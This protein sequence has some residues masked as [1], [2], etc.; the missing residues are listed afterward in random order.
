MGTKKVHTGILFRMSN[1][2]KG[3]ITNIILVSYREFFAQ[4][5]VRIGFAQFVLFFAPQSHKANI[6]YK[7]MTYVVRQIPQNSKKSHNTPYIALHTLFI[8]LYVVH[9]VLQN[10]VHTLLTLSTL[11]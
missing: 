9:N 8:M 5:H 2:I 3:I 10:T 1:F 6:T 4:P 11:F 7:S